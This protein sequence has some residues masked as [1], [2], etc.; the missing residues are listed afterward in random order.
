MEQAYKYTHP[1]GDYSNEVSPSWPSSYAS[2]YSN[3]FPISEMKSLKKE[4]SETE[5]STHLHTPLAVNSLPY[6]TPSQQASG[7][8]SGQNASWSTP[9]PPTNGSLSFLSVEPTQEVPSTPDWPQQTF[10]YSESTNFSYHQHHHY[11]QQL[12]NLSAVSMQS[13]TPI[14]GVGEMSHSRGVPSMDPVRR[15]FQQIRFSFDSSGSRSSEESCGQE[16]NTSRLPQQ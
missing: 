2:L 3:Q 12:H 9:S 11:Q 6:C 16:A 14:L 1:I 10:H 15:T 7:S 13:S 4:D 8:L 5:K